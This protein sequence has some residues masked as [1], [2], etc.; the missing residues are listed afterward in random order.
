MLKKLIIISSAAA[1]AMLGSTGIASAHE[2]GKGPNG[3]TNC[4]SNDT[5]HQKNK[6]HQLVGGNLT[7]QDAETNVLGAQAT[8]PAGI[9]PSLLNN[10]HL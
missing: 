7:A 5:T 10:N 8:R 2:H 6:G 9:C 3:N 4:T 1:V